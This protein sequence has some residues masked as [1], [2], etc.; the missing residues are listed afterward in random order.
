[1][2]IVA[3]PQN[4]SGAVALS[5]VEKVHLQR[6]VELRTNRRFRR[7]RGQAGFPRYRMP[8]KTSRQKTTIRTDRSGD[9]FFAA[10]RF[11]MAR[12]PK[13][14]WFRRFSLFYRK[15]AEHASRLRGNARKRPEIV[16][17]WI[18]FCAVRG[19]CGLS[20]TVRT[21]IGITC[22]FPRHH[23]GQEAGVVLQLHARTPGRR[24][25]RRRG[26]S[27]CAALQQ[28]RSVSIRIMQRIAPLFHRLL[29]DR[30]R[31]SSFRSIMRP[32]ESMQVHLADA[33]VV[34]RDAEVLEIAV[35]SSDSAGLSSAIDAE[36]YRLARARSSEMF[37]MR[38]IRSAMR[39]SRCVDGWAI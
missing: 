15:S 9:A 27:S 21:A 34:V 30:L 4:K 2:S 26:N 38:A 13:I 10:R 3:S 1:M 22:F 18:R 28:T 35:N 31:N 39:R 16:S 33:E 32:L 14:G 19:K 20:P 24:Y 29:H 7:A 23:A 5:D 36:R 11:F 37:A 17:G 6:A 25:P 12:P 8:K